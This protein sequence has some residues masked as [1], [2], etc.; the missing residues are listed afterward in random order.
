MSTLQFHEIANV[1]PLIEGKEFEELVADVRAYGVREPIV[2]FQ[3][4]ILDGRNRWRAAQQAAVEC[5]STEYEGDDPVGFVVSLNLRRRHLDES[6]RGVVAASIAKL[7]RGANQHSPIGLPT[8]ER[9][10]E[11]LNVGLNTVKRA[12]S[13]ACNG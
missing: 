10:A 1:F 2:L 13:R 3:G 8:Q 7:P 5:P 6:Q 4:K 9:A 11:M 12:P